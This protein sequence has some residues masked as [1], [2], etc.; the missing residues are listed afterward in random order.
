[1]N[2][3]GM[4]FKLTWGD[5]TLELKGDAVAVHREL[6]SLKASGIGRIAD[7]FALRDSLTRPRTGALSCTWR[8]FSTGPH[9]HTRSSSG[10]NARTR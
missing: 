5:M 1:M 10:A 3:P 9:A 7:F 8:A 6:E 4:R 2:D